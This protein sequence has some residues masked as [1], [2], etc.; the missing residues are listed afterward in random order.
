M[1]SYSK[2]MVLFMGSRTYVLTGYR[3]CY[4]H[5][6]GLVDPDEWHLYIVKYFNSPWTAY[7]AMNLNQCVAKNALF[8]IVPDEFYY[9]EIPK[10]M[11][12]DNLVIIKWAESRKK[13]FMR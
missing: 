2:H 12:A 8:E 4:N 3:D 1:T 6:R 11:L 7:K 5:I 13:L 10:T 9:T